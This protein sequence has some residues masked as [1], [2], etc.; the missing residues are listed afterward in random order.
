MGLALAMYVQDNEAYPAHS[1]ASN[2]V[3]R[4]RWPDH[5]Y[6]HVKNEALFLCSS[7]NRDIV[8]KTFAHNP[9]VKYGGYGYNYQYLG[10]SRFPYYAPDAA[11][12][13]PAETVAIGDTNAVRRDN[14]TTIAGEYVIDP[15]LPSARGA[16]PTTPGDGFYGAGAECGSGAA[17]PGFWGCRATPGER[18]SQM[19]SVTFADGHSKA[20][21]LSRMDDHNGDGTRDN[22]F[23]NGFADAT[24]R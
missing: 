15:P 17:G 6:P 10:N 4:T 13:V 11:V 9:A 3:P 22:G 12:F 20:M 2:Q 1:S 7:A 8:N 18:H 16:R 14:G 5:V 23:W 24:Q 21:K 19:V